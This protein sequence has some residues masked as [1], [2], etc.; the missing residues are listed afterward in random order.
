[1]LLYLVLFGCILLDRCIYNQGRQSLTGHKVKCWQWLTR[2]NPFSPIGCRANFFS[3]WF[4][5]FL[6][7]K[8]LNVSGQLVGVSLCC[9]HTCR[10]TGEPPHILTFCSLSSIVNECLWNISHS[11][12]PW[13]H[14]VYRRMQKVP[15]CTDWGQWHKVTCEVIT[16]DS[17]LLV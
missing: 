8:W 1:M 9:Q 6:W 17:L 2:E 14:K 5:H 11:K 12:W 3:G 10:V 13:M 16:E 15:C 4:K 7:S